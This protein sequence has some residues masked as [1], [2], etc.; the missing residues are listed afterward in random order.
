[1]AQAATLPPAG[2][3]RTSDGPRTPLCAAAHRFTRSS[4]PVRS[5]ST[6]SSSTARSSPSTTEAISERSAAVTELSFESGDLVV[7]RRESS[8]A[9]VEAYRDTL[10]QRV[11][12]VDQRGR[13]VR[14]SSLEPVGPTHELLTEAA[15]P[16]RAGRNPHFGDVPQTLRLA[17]GR[18]RAEQ[19]AI[20]VDIRV[21]RRWH[22]RAVALTR[23]EPHVVACRQ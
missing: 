23:P 19:D 5:R 14:A 21:H 2:R 6:A 10:E 8:E 4:C 16:A 20:T 15:T 22:P 12:T 7:L 9:V 17:R 13:S 11:T 3:A 1:M 18:P